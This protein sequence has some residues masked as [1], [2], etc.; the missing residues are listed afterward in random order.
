MESPFQQA[1]IHNHTSVK[2]KQEAGHRPASRIFAASLRHCVTAYFVISG[3]RGV[4]TFAE[5]GVAFA[6]A[7]AIAVDFV[8]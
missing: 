4:T 8:R 7:P 5:G 2:N 3:S 6:G 1:P